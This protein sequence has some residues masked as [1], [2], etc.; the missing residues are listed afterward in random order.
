MKENNKQ[1]WKNTESN[2]F[3]DEK[4]SEDLNIPERVLI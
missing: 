3:V 2:I 1:T 4:N